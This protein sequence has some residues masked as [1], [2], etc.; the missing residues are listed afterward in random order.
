MF[1]GHLPHKEGRLFSRE[2]NFG[3][4]GR[5]DPGAPSAKAANLRRAEVV[6]PY[7]CGWMFQY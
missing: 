7:K 6:P 5:D 1:C 3:V 4:A 2:V